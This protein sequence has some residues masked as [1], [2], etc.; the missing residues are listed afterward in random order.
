[1]ETPFYATVAASPAVQALLGS[2]PRV[3]PWGENPNSPVVYPYV[4]FQLASG[5]PE[6][7]LAGGSR[8]DEGTLQ[9]DIWAKA[10]DDARAVRAALRDAVEPRCRITSWRGESKD[11]GTGSYRTGFDCR[12]TVLRP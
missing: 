7:Q 10:A 6:P 2:P 12:W 5:S 11:P 3:Y 1:M 8:V 9:I 4:T